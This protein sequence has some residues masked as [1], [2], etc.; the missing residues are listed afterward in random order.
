MCSI[1]Q[2]GGVLAKKKI[3]F[4]PVFGVVLRTRPTMM[5]IRRESMFPMGLFNY[6]DSGLHAVKE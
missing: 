6:G 5:M 2:A 3:F 1:I 4:A